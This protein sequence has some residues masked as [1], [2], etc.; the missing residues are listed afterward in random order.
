MPDIRSI[1]RRAVILGIFT[2]VFTVVTYGFTQGDVRLSLRVALPALPAS[3]DIGGGFSNPDHAVPYSIFD[4]LIHKD[5]TSVEPV[6]IP[7]LATSWERVSDR[8][9]ELK[10]RK[11]VRLVVSTYFG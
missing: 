4:S 8:V 7:G 1:I 6:Y 2:M 11:G 9:L 10:L 5:H 3:L